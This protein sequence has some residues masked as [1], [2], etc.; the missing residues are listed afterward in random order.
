[1][2]IFWE[3]RIPLTSVESLEIAAGR[4]WNGKYLHRMLQSLLKK[5]MIEVCGMEQYGR[6]YA[7]Q[8]LPAVTKE[9]YAARLVMSKGIGINSLAEI[10]VAMVKEAEESDEEELIQQLEGM[11]EE[12]KQRG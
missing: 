8:F 2:E 9:Q 10:A 5:G 1:M 6:Q 7:R 4:S 12:L 11:I 3:R